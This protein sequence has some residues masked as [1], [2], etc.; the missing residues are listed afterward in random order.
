MRRA[1][2]LL[3]IYALTS[4]RTRLRQL[5]DRTKKSSAYPA[6]NPDEVWKN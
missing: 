4:I 1:S 2:T 6:E 3:Y 5:P